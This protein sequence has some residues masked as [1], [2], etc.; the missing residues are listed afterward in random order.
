[1]NRDF[2][3]ITLCIGL[4]YDMIIYLRG[5]AILYL[6]VIVIDIVRFG[7]L[8]CLGASSPWRLS[9]VQWYIMFGS[10]QYETCLLPVF[11]LLKFAGEYQVF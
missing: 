6:L 10:V 3:F 5:T 8:Y 7:L 9:S 4:Q 1:M 11:W 2:C